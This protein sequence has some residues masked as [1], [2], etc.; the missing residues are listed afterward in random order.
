MAN[1]TSHISYSNDGNV[2]LRIYKKNVKYLLKHGL[3]VLGIN[4][5]KDTFLLYNFKRK[6]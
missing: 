4:K 5:K 6:F 3:S 1:F 2:K